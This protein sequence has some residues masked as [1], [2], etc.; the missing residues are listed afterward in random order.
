MSSDLDHFC[1][2]RSVAEF[3]KNIAKIILLTDFI[4]NEDGLRREILLFL[5]GF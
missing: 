1:F 4:S 3:T 5:E 2:Y